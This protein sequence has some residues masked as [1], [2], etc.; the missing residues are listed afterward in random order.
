MKPIW[1][2]TIFSLAAV[3]I[4]ILLVSI[5]LPNEYHNRETF[6]IRMPGTGAFRVI[7]TFDTYPDWFF[8]PAKA[9][10][11]QISSIDGT[12]RTRIDWEYEGSG[13]TGSLIL[14]ERS[15]DRSDDFS[16]RIRMV[17]DREMNRRYS[18]RE[19][20]LLQPALGSMLRIQWD[21]RR[22]WTFPYNI[23]AWWGNYEEEHLD[24]HREAMERLENYLRTHFPTNVFDGFEVS[25]SHMSALHLL[26]SAPDTVGR[27]GIG[28][29]SE[30][31]DDL[32][33]Y[34]GKND[35]NT[36]G[37]PMGLLYRLPAPDSVVKLMGIPMVDS[38]PGRRFDYLRIPGG[39]SLQVLYSGDLEMAARA[40]GALE[41]Y[42]ET[43]GV[44]IREPLIEQYFYDP[45]LHG[46][47]TA[48]R[49]LLIG[50]LE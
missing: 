30:L 39:M 24:R 47:T 46:D 19:E 13:E 17:S 31:L 28:F 15:A 50:F 14:A 12:A 42:I 3:L 43:Y 9:V 21:R 27:P 33:E 38:L 7:S 8:Q 11:F 20:F 16:Q 18:V 41:D 25:R 2:Y 26:V 45:K 6:E 5:L 37:M 1:K 29:S 49:T 32:A 22:I 36:D 23:S 35:L 34:V 10:E 48:W 40:R 4:L 44:A